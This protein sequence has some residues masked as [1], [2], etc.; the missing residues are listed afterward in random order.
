MDGADLMAVLEGQIDLNDLLR[1]KKAI[2]AQRGEV[3]APV[4]KII[5]GEM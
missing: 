2:A 3:F 4:S 1:R 5:L